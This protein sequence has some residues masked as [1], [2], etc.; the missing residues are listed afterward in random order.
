MKDSYQGAM[1]F[2]TRKRRLRRCRILRK[3]ERRRLSKQRQQ[4]K[5]ELI[6]KVW[7]QVI[8]PIAFD[9]ET[10]KNHEK[11]TAF[12]ARL[13]DLLVKSKRSVLIDFSHTKQMVA[14]GTLLFKAEL[15]RTIKVIGRERRIRCRPPKNDKTGQVL[16]QVGIYG[17]LNYR[18]HIKPCDDDVVYWWHTSCSGAV[19]EEYERVLGQFDSQLPQNLQR[20]LYVGIVEAMT[21]ANQHA[22]ELTRADGL[23]YEDLDK[24]W[25]MFTQVR[26]EKLSVC[27][28][29]LGIGIPRSLPHKRPS[30]WANI[31]AKFIGKPPDGEAIRA[32]VDDSRSRTGQAHRGK[33]LKQLVAAMDGSKEG[34]LMIYSNSGCYFWRKDGA[35][36]YEKKLDYHESIL[37]TLIIWRVPLVQEE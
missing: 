9:I 37:G 8:A 3:R 10:E 5:K 25:W 29:D 12:H 26:D 27:F 17:L 18:S 16:E 15:E 6:R 7:T 33:G 19:G 21:N 35:R 24:R 32:A 2:D 14:G 1:K 20:G 11:I 31:K 4:V 23:N 13:R 36:T 30:L 28:C 34:T 22:Y